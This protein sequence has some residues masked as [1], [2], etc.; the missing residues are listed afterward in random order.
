[1]WSVD[2]MLGFVIDVV[3]ELAFMRVGPGIFIGTLV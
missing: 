1:M 2:D 3:K